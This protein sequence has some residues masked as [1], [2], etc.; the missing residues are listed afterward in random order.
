MTN[1][2]HDVIIVGAGLAG[3]SCAIKLV[4]NGKSDYR[5]V[6][7]SRLTV[8]GCSRSSPPLVESTSPTEMFTVSERWASVK[9]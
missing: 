2:K 5:I 3:L 4:E 7:A 6:V 1:D 8:G 9:T